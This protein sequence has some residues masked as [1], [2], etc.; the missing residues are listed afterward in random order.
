M[1]QTNDSCYDNSFN[2]NIIPEIVVYCLPKQRLDYQKNNICVSKDIQKYHSFILPLCPQ[3]IDPF[4]KKY[5][6]SEKIHLIK[7]VN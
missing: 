2:V 4:D 6:M 7:I 3:K 5:G 1:A